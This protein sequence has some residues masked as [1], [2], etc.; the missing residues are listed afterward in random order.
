MEDHIANVWCRSADA[1]HSVCSSCC[2]CLI[3]SDNKRQCYPGVQLL[4]NICCLYPVTLILESY[5]P[6]ADYF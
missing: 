5:V 6:I 3:F 2:F 4:N 1:T